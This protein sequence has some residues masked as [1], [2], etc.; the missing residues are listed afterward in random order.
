MYTESRSVLNDLFESSR[1]LELVA[2]SF[3]EALVWLLIDYARKHRNDDKK[4]RR[5]DGVG[6]DVVVAIDV[7]S[8][9]EG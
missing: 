2:E 4:E 1:I 9:G 5:T 7:S 3:V 6:T 8:S